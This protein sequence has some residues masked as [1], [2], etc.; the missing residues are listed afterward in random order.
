MMTQGWKRFSTEALLRNEH[1]VLQWQPEIQ[2]TV[3][4]KVKKFLDGKFKNKNIIVLVPKFNKTRVIPIKD[5][6]RFEFTHDFPDYTGFAMALKSGRAWSAL[7]Q[8]E[9]SFPDVHLDWPSE[10]VNRPLETSGQLADIAS[11]YVMIDGEK[12]YQMPELTVQ[13][14]SPYSA[15][16]YKSINTELLEEVDVDYALELLNQMPEICIYWVTSSNES[17]IPSA[18]MDPNAAETSKIDNRFFTHT[19]STIRDVRT[20]ETR[21]GLNNHFLHETNRLNPGRFLDPTIPSIK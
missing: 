21:I 10:N 15:I 1:P 18:T 9:Q 7:E 13:G 19:P 17:R 11:G 12:V 16:A 20:G 2:Q 4:G 3:R 6:G 14:A 8:V 5:D